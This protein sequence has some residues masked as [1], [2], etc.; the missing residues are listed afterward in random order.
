[1]S[2]S[3]T[4]NKN[5]IDDALAW[6]AQHFEFRSSSR[7]TDHPWATTLALQTVAETTYLKI[8]P[9][10]KSNAS[11]MRAL[12][13]V[14]RRFSRYVPDLMASDSDR[15]FFLYRD[16]GGQNL[17]SS[18]N[19][20][21]RN[22]VLEV[23]ANIQTEAVSDVDLIKNLP[24][25]KCR[26]QFALLLEF[27]ADEPGS[28]PKIDGSLPASYFLGA[29]KADEYLTILT[30]AQ[31]A[32]EVLLSKADTLPLTINHCDL[33][34]KNV[35]RRTDG[36]MVIF[37]WD[38]A[39]AAPPGLSLHA[40]FSGSLRPIS[41]LASSEENSRSQLKR[42]RSVIEHY[43]AHLSATGD[44]EADQL[45]NCLPGALC[46]GVISYLLSFSEYPVADERLRAR[47]GKN[48]SRRFSDLLDVAQLAVGMHGSQIEQQAFASALERADRASRAKRFK[49][50]WKVKDRK[51]VASVT[52]VD[53]GD[54]LKIKLK[55]SDM[56]GVFPSLTLSDSEQQ[57]EEMS[58]QNTKLAVELFK[59]H[60]TLMVQ[61]AIP[62]ALVKRCH[63]EFMEQNERYFHDERHSDALRVGDKRFMITLDFEGGF[64][65]P[66]LFAS[67]I[68][69]PMLKQ[70]LTP[71]FILGS[72]TAVASLPGSADQRM[73]K[74]NQ[75]LFPEVDDGTLPSFS[76]AMIVPLIPLDQLTGATRVVKGSHRY[77]SSESKKMPYQDPIVPL[78]SCFFMDSRLTHQGLANNST[79]VRPIVS[80]VYQRPWYRDNLNYKKQKPVNINAQQ[81]DLVRDDLK[82][83]VEWAV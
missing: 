60:G 74:D 46:A 3:I 27:L 4:A 65:D 61:N 36:S 39:V 25:V 53:E 2:V 81:F 34:V 26:D 70:L 83:L 44:Y 30:A 67:P 48:M 50:T 49:D 63:S 33:R 80:I 76:I 22:A 52:S 31:S 1:M 37:D 69:T 45:Q 59:R 10:D 71:E 75:A 62:K 72:L 35:A 57:A 58:P 11:H 20:E 54:W 28:A 14:A 21:L 77:S 38:E 78:S 43:V 7:V 82:H 68:L 40:L 5:H 16:H 8:L 32:F 18:W 66:N 6:A 73:H 42:D 12:E 23:Y 41:A 64:A 79:Q 47:I 55:Q 15:G 51:S 13:S 9:V 29:Q 24:V 19:T 17:D 56:E